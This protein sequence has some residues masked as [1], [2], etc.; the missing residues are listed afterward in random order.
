MGIFTI[1]RRFN[2][3]K[4][5]EEREKF[6]RTMQDKGVV[7]NLRTKVRYEALPAMYED[8]TVIRRGKEVIKK[9]VVQRPVYFYADFVYEVNGVQVVEEVK[10]TKKPFNSLYRLKKAMMN[11]FHGI[12]I[13]EI[14]EPTVWN[15]PNFNKQPR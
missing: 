13:V 11:Y 12:K 1:R 5:R 2:I 7:S 4:V 14:S 6:L 8:Q 3:V 15:N 9:K 10:D